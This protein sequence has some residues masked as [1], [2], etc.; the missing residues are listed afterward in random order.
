VERNSAGSAEEGKIV[1]R[2]TILTMLVF[3]V[4]LAEAETREITVNDDLRA[5]ITALRPGDELHLAGGTY[6]LDSR[7]N[8]TVV[9]TIDQ[10]IVIRAKEGEDVLIDMTTGAQNVL[11]VQNSQYLE[12]RDLRFRGGSHGIRLMSS[13]FVTIDGCEIFETGDVAISANSGGTYE[14]LIIRGNHIHHTNGT[15]EGMYLG[16][17]NDACR[18]MNSLI[19]QN[20]IHH[21]N[22]PSVLVHCFDGLTRI[23]AFNFRCIECR[24]DEVIGIW[25]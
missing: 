5:A 9:G 19:E 1:L 6:S 25:R 2:I 17:N 15:G 21:T 13:N 14:G 7:F 23:P 22:G 10:P 20:Y 11:E 4:S 18:V 12:I 3:W 8:I 16:C 24:S